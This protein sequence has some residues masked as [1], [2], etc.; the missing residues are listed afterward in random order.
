M[1]KQLLVVT[2]LAAGASCLPGCFGSGE[3]GVYSEPGPV[4]LESAPPVGFYE[5]GIYYDNFDVY[6]HHHGDWDRDRAWRE[7][8]G[9]PREHRRAERHEEHRM[10]EH[11]KRHE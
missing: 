7:W 8:E 6:W 11:A 3:V 10:H 5:G 2:A 1:V 4:Y 9:H